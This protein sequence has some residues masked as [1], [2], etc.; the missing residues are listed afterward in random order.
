[1]VA[2]C[3]KL[4]QGCKVLSIKANQFRLLTFA[5]D[6]LRVHVAPSKLSLCP[7]GKPADLTPQAFE[8]WK[9]RAQSGLH[10]FVDSAIASH[11]QEQQAVLLKMAQN[12]RSSGGG[13]AVTNYLIEEDLGDV[14]ASSK[15]SKR[16]RSSSRITAK[17]RAAAAAEAAALDLEGQLFEAQ[18]LQ[19]ELATVDLNH[20]PI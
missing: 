3:M 20:N 15:G 12:G 18:M 4:L 14:G 10:S 11:E 2:A 19:Q 16:Q 8:I 1:M 9:G 7:G 5:E 13:P 6:G 17:S